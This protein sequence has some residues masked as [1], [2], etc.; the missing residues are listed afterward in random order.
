MTCAVAAGST[1]TDISHTFSV[2]VNDTIEYAVT[3]TNGSPTLF[4]STQLICH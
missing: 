2:A 1:C 4:Y 3:Q